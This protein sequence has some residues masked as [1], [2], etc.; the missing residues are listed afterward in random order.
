LIDSHARTL[1]A[2]Y[3]EVAS[4]IDAGTEVTV[5]DEGKLHLSALEAIPDPASLIQLRKLVQ[6]ML[7]RIGLPEGDRRGHVLAAGVRRGV[8]VGL[9]RPLPPKPA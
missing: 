6:V 1:D 8:H 3:Q 9:R 5:D 4:R 2:A 7:P